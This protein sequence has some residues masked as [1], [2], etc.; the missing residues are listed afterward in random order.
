MVKS[1]RA[2]PARV[3]QKLLVLFKKRILNELRE[4]MTLTA[5]MQ[6]MRIRQVEMQIPE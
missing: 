6:R 4:K 5:G 3:K 1:Q 2:R